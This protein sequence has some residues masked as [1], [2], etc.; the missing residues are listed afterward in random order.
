MLLA[1]R[2]EMSEPAGFPVL[3]DACMI[4]LLAGFSASGQIKAIAVPAH[5]NPAIAS[6]PS[7]R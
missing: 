7:C 5:E 2:R 6:G 1:I 3:K 4:R